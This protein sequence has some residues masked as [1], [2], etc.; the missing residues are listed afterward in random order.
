MLQ[1]RNW[2]NLLRCCMVNTAVE[3]VA[4]VAI[5]EVV[6][7]TNVAEVVVVAIKKMLLF[8]LCTIVLDTFSG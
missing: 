4:E 6:V 7:T 2:H 1:P 3:A 5:V 8:A